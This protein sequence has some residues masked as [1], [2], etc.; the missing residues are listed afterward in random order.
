[1]QEKRLVRFHD[2][3]IEQNSSFFSSY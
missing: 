3:F 1:M 2:L